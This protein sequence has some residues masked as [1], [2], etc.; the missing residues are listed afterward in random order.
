MGRVLLARQH[1]LSRDVAVKTLHDPN[2]IEHREILL[3]EAKITGG[4]E[5]PG[6]IPVHLL[7]VDSQG[8]PVLVMKRIEGTSWRELLTTPTHALWGTLL[9]QSNDNDRLIAHIEILTQV[10]NAL[11]FAHSKGIIH[12]D[13]KPDNVMVGTFGEVYLVDWGIAERVEPNTRTLDGQI[14]GTP[15]YMA[16]EMVSGTVGPLGVHT[17]VYLLGSTLHEIL[18]G[19]ARHRGATALEALRAAR[20]STAIDY[21][22]HIPVELANLCNAATA[23]S[24][25]DRPTSALVFRQALQEYLRRRNTTA[26]INSAYERLALLNKLVTEEKPNASRIRQ[27][28]I[29]CRF[30]FTQVIKDWPENPL[31]H[32]GLASCLSILCTYQIDRKDAIAARELFDEMQNPSAQ[33]HHRL[34]ELEREIEQQKQYADSLAQQE[35]DRDIRLGSVSRAIFTVVMVLTGSVLSYTMGLPEGKAEAAWRLIQTQFAVVLFLCTISIIFR[36]RLFEHVASRR[37]LALLFSALLTVLM[38]RIHGWW[39]EQ[40]VASIVGNDLLILALAA[41]AGAI[42]VDSV[43]WLLAVMY[44]LATL[45]ISQMPDKA[46]RAFDTVMLASMLLMNIITVKRE[47]N[48]SQILITQTPNSKK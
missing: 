48:L 20:M 16:P 35:R 5:H 38:N 18:T 17:D 19:T 32:E 29:E 24:I 45:A 25:K 12:R 8:V 26:M 42:N 14:V 43:L 11:Q 13:I 41:A 9:S 47:K 31:C 40:S 6:I 22:D 44:V 46:S 7:G 21:S 33:L 10:C 23:S 3:R 37:L 39:S 36:K 34:I 15:S 2:I 1:S 27:I 30:A 4:L 28:S